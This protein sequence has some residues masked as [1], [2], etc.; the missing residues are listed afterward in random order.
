MREPHWLFARHL[1]KSGMAYEILSS[2]QMTDADAKTV[3]DFRTPGFTLMQKAGKA[4]AAAAIERF[5]KR[6]VLVLCGPGNNGGDGF[7]AAEALKKKKWD[8]RIACSCF[9]ETLS[10][11]ALRAADSWGGDV[12]Q[13]ADIELTGEELV[14]DA[15]F[16]TGLSRPLDGAIA[17]ILMMVRESGA[18]V[19]AVDV[20]TGLNS[21]TGACDPATPQADLTV[22]F[23]RKKY[24]HM[25]M[26][27][28][29]ACGE[30][31]VADIGIPDEVLDGVS[32]LVRG[33][34]PDQWGEYL[35]DK[36]RNSHKYDHG[37]VVVLGGRV[38]TGA[39]CLAGKSA[40][41]M[42]TGLVTIASAPETCP[43]YRAFSPSLIVEPMA[44]LARFKEHIKDPRRNVVLLGPG[45]GFENPAALKK[46]VF[47]ACQRDPKMICVLDADALTV[48]ADDPRALWRVTGAHC[49][50]TPHEG[51]FA[52]V[53]PDLKGSKIERALAA[54]ARSKSVVVLK[55]PDTVIAAPDGRCVVNGTGTG[56][57]ATAGAGDVLAGMIAGLAARSLMDPFDTACACAYLHGK[58]A[59]AIGPGLI[60]ADL[61]DVIPMMLEV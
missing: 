7:I 28:M 39:A 20:P 51:E 26:P 21:D 18:S 61:P 55:G 24:G 16:G 13:F 47:D 35:E 15:I 6:P 45:A 25:L 8:V 49:I 33:N 54:A 22:T 9:P 14:I 46:A 44:E 10:G 41:R 23:F 11:D 5:E 56:W 30:I 53:F 50:L 2:L 43:T 3:R 17:D 29:D 36:P 60:S 38:M 52:R 31:I 4:V 40:L 12:F 32:P 48:F 42:G 57:L 34:A 19:V 27:G 58:A 59:E 1:P 37:H